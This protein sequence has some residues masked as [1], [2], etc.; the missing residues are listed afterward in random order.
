MAK[1]SKIYF[2]SIFLV[3]FTD[4]CSSCPAG[5]Y[6]P[7]DG[8]FQPQQC[9]LGNYSS[10][11]ASVCSVCKAGHYC[12]SNTTTYIEMSTKYICPA[13]QHCPEGLTHQPVS[14]INPCWKGNYCVQGNEVCLNL[15]IKFFCC[16]VF[17][18]N[19]WI[20]EL[21]QVAFEYIFND[22]T[23]SK[24]WQSCIKMPIAIRSCLILFSAFLLL[25]KNCQV[26]TS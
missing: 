5:Y 21:R 1:Q 7:V 4:D 12:M 8:T 17:E 20:P 23:G 2:K 24:S 19:I 18:L 26:Y 6:C 10:P 15:L 3:L 11:G 9:N 16:F 13:G 22:F 25:K 14:A